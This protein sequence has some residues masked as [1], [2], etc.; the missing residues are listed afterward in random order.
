MTE[1]RRAPSPSAIVWARSFASRTARSSAAYF[2]TLSWVERY[3]IDET[4]YLGWVLN[5]DELLEQAAAA[6]LELVREVLLPAWLPAPGAPEEPV[7]HR[8]FLFAPV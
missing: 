1:L 5:R 2:A 8:G 7:G 4:E 3:W 6:G